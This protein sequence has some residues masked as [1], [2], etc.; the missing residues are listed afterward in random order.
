M[1]F[2]HFFLNCLFQSTPT[3]TLNRMTMTA[4]PPPLP[5]QPQVKQRV[6]SG[7][8][9]KI[10]ENF[11]IIDEDVIFQPSSVKGSMPQAGDRVLVE[12]TYS[13][14]LPFKW[15]ATRVQVIAPP[16]QQQPQKLLSS[17]TFNSNSGTEN[18]LEYSFFFHNFIVHKS[19]CR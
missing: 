15:N 4:A 1:T 17:T 14:S 3:Y 2:L 18:G 12:A 13:G 6:F 19:L 11:G 7:T 16:P 8:V 5:Q 9:N 10:H